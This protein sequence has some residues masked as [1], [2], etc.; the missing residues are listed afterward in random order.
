MRK[1]R[2]KMFCEAGKSIVGESQ[3]LTLVPLTSHS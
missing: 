3:V 2:L 1:L